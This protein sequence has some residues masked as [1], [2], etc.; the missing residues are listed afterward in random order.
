MRILGIDH[1]ARQIGLALSDP[2][3]KIA[4]PLKTVRTEDE[5]CREAQ[6]QGAGAIVIGLPLSRSG[7][8]TR[9]SRIVR[10]FGAALEKRLQLPVIFEDE[11][12][13]TALAENNSPRQKADA[14][15]AALILQ[16][17]LDRNAK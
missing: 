1:G 4:L 2:S 7:R 13:T 12:F 3:G 8:E 9:Q 15:A 10:R 5:V 16:E 14:S 11:R 6:A 17:Y